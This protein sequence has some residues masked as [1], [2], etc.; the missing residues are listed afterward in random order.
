LLLV[1][2]ERR[3]I[4]KKLLK[5]I[6]KTATYLLEQSDRVSEETRQSVRKG[7]DRVGDRVSELRDQ[8]RD[9]YGH[10]DHTIR[11]VICFTAGVGVGVGA[12]LL[13]APASGEV[14]RNSIG[15]KAQAV[16]SRVRDRFS[17]KPTH[18]AT[19]TEGS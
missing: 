2:A 14:V 5:S 13:C 1:F 19:G 12:A 18:A 10:E 17:P 4:L 7:V 3:P 11:N 15:E 9:L 6:L 8:A 16:G